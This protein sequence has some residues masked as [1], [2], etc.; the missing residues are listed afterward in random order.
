MYIYIIKEIKLL[1]LNKLLLLLIRVLIWGMLFGKHGWHVLKLLGLNIK[2]AFTTGMCKLI[3]WKCWQ[4]VK[5]FNSLLLFGG[6]VL[7]ILLSWQFGGFSGANDL[8]NILLSPC[9]WLYQFCCTFIQEHVCKD[10]FICMYDEM[11]SVT[12]YEFC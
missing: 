12:S 11:L 1:T 7:C 10:E 5:W 6:N 9:C 2:L 3:N 4:M 8:Q